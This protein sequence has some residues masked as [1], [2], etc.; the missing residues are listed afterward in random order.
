MKNAFPAVSRRR[1]LMG[2]SRWSGLCTV[3]SC[4]PRF[5]LRGS[6]LDES[7]LKKPI[8]DKGFA[9]VRPIG[10][11]VYATIS[12]RAK[13]MQTRSNGGFILGRDAVLL[14][15]GFQTPEGASFQINALRMVSRV[16]IRG[17]ILTH[18]HFDHSLGSSF[19]GGNNIP[20]WAH[21]K[22]AHRMIEKYP[23]WQ[24]ESRDRFIAPWLERVRRADTD[25]ERQHAQSDVDGLL[26][27]FDPVTQNVL[28][29][30]NH[31]LNPSDM[32]MTLDLGKLSV[33]IESYPGH[34]DTDLIIRVP[35]QN[36]VFSGD[37]LVNAQYPTNIDGQPTPW[38]A[39]LAK[40]AQFDRE[41]L[42]VPGHGAPCG[43]EAV[44][45]LITIFDDIAEQAEKM[46]KSGVPIDEAVEGYVVPEKWKNFRRFS[47]GFTIGRT[48]Q[49]LY[50]EWQG[51][52]ENILTYY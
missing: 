34:T 19:Y 21:I 14:I 46:Y 13:G 33:V 17:A 31:P 28:A 4:F 30:P 15:E 8:I 40:F 36:I 2:A 16:P 29:L 47:W 32:P 44:T 20:V 45:L 35:D 41:T 39:T 49:Q 52:P 43:L 27:M 38:R 23:T 11:G 6:F 3:A 48:I 1:F 18:F 25:A 10:D 12:D 22:V 50:S 37:L 24:V 9:L 51:K 5:A 7:R 42:F 26:G